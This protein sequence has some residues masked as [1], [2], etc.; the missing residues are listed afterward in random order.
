[1]YD[2][3]GI[4][5]TNLILNSKKMQ[6]VKNDVTLKMEYKNLHVKNIIKDCVN[7]AKCV[8]INHS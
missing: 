5:H 7:Q 3:K 1:M 6:N 8:K 2:S 4:Y